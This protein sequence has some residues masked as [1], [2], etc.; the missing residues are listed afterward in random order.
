MSA[1]ETAASLESLA[2]RL[3]G[4][5]ITRGHP[6][7][8]RARHVWN[9]MFD[10]RPLAIA[11]ALGAVDVIAVVNHA[12]E[13][14]I[15]LSVRGGGHSSAGFSTSDGGIVLD[16]SLMKG[17]WV[18]PGDKTAR[19]QAGALWGDVDRET[20]AYGLAVPGGQISHTGISSPQM[21]GWSPRRRRSAPSCSG[22]SAADPATLASSSPSST[23][24]TM[25]ARW[26]SAAR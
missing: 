26:S 7:Y 19:A 20:Q 18:D 11:R 21:A 8:E 24:C 1:I 22:A 23:G 12:R 10:K 4:D 17:V 6:G 3:R 9:G 2:G 16:L 14:G 5:V 15:E 25:S 13:T